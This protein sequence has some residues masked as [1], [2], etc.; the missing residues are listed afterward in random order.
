MAE[1]MK[2]KHTFEYVAIAVISGFISLNIG[3]S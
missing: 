3:N 2:V 1:F